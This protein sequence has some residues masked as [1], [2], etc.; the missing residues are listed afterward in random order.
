M[1]GWEG[2]SSKTVVSL[3]WCILNWESQPGLRFS[4]S[5]IWQRVRERR[6]W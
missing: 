1:I 5:V 4:I 2:T 3:D 6:T